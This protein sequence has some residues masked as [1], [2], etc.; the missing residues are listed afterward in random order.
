MYIYIH[1][2]IYIYTIHTYIY[3]YALHNGSCNEVVKVA[4]Q[5]YAA[6]PASVK[7]ARRIAMLCGKIRG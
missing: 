1:T 5:S 6:V 7:A 2:F 3:I 4:E